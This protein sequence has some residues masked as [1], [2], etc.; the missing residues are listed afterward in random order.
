MKRSPRSVVYTAA[1]CLWYNWV[2]KSYI[3]PAFWWV[4]I[5]QLFSSGC[6][7]K[8]SCI[9]ASMANNPQGGL[10]VGCVVVVCVHVCVC[11]HLGEGLGYRSQTNRLPPY[12]TPPLPLSFPLFIPPFFSCSCS[13]SSTLFFTFLSFYSLSFFLVSPYYSFTALFMQLCLWSQYRLLLFFLLSLS[14]TSLHLHC[15]CPTTAVFICSLM[16]VATSLASWFICCLL[17]GFP[18]AFE[19]VR[20]RACVCDKYKSRTHMRLS[21]RGTQFSIPTH[22]GKINN[23]KQLTQSQTRCKGAKA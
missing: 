6:Q 23:S 5:G 9:S 15:S 3:S 2:R 4:V 22:T 13:H 7:Q 18:L 11:A 19:H 8:W 12:C 17:F 16:L 21:M 1:D 10:S 20:T 14:L